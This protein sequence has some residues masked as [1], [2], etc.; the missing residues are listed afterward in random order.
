MEAASGV[1]DM[2]ACGGFVVAVS[3]WRLVFRVMI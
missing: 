2:R 1:S 3:L